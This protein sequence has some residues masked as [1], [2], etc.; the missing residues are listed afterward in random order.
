MKKV[1]RNQNILSELLEN[2]VLQRHINLVKRTIRFGIVGMSG[3]ILD[4]S[5]T[6][7]LLQCL[8]FNSYFANGIGFI[9]AAS[10][11]FYWNK[12]W[13]F[14]SE[15]RKVTLQFFKFMIVSIVG[16]SINSL[17]IFFL[18][19]TFEINFLCCKIIAT[20]IVFVWNF[21]INSAITY[22]DSKSC[23]DSRA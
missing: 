2:D 10:N 4:F 23:G 17:V 22:Q 18:M 19:S 7:Y 9:L 20:I 1:N 15:N 14:K 11:N 12:K 5:L 6:W 8:H 3:A 16:L 21:A 13:T